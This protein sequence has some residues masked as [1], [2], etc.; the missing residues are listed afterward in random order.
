MVDRLEMDYGDQMAFVR[1]DVGDQSARDAVGALRIRGHPTVVLLTADGEEA[2]R[3]V[4]P[5]DEETFAAAII[6]VVR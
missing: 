4:G 3:F 5:V 2:A 6:K 1:L